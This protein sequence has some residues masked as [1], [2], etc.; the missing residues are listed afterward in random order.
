[1]TVAEVMDKLLR[2]RPFFDQS[3]GGITFSGGEP[4]LQ[5]DFLLAL[6]RACRE[7]ALHTAV[8]TCGYAETPTLLAMADLADLVLYDIKTLD[9]R[10]HEDQ[11]GV[12]NEVI[13]SNLR[14]LSGAHTELWIRVPL[15]PG[16]NSDQESLSAIADFLSAISGVRQ[17]NVLP[18]HD[19]GAHKQRQLGSV[20]QQLECRSQWDRAARQFAPGLPTCDMDESLADDT[21]SRETGS[22]AALQRAVEIFRAAGFETHVG[23]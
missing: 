22:A 1:M 20:T 9:A 5:P 18:Y 21:G 15:I 17:V 19:L 23:G 7:Q 13:L 3:Q 10:L 16:F 11:T 4:L 2:D 6:L 8:D 12:S 14:T